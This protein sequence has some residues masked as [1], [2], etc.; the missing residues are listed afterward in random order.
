MVAAAAGHPAVLRALLNQHAQP[1][2]QSNVRLPSIPLALSMMLIPFLLMLP[3]LAGLYF[4]AVE[5]I[6]C[7]YYH[8]TVVL[9]RKL[10]ICNPDMM[11]DM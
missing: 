8:L 10:S 1:D 7:F 2:A 6:R 4:S 3:R 9:C 11:A 5:C